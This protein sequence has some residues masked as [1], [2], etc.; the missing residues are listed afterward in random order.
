MPCIQLH[1]RREEEGGVLHKA[2]GGG[3]GGAAKGMGVGGVRGGTP[4][5][6]TVYG[7]SNTSLLWGKLPK[8]K[9]TH[10]LTGRRSPPLQWD[11]P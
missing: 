10:P 3:K 9:L 8:T 4:P 5:P 1:I 7:C 6:P 11:P 2:S